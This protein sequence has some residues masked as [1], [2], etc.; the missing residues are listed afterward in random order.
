MK[1]TGWRKGHE[2]KKKL[3]KAH[4]ID[5][6]M[7]LIYDE[8]DHILGVIGGIKDAGTGKMPKPLTMVQADAKAI[9]TYAKQVMNQLTKIASNRR[10]LFIDC[11]KV[12]EGRPSERG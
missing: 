11:C 7:K 12:L 3:M 5:E 9:Q 4:S 10:E 2:T 8:A 6:S 1:Q